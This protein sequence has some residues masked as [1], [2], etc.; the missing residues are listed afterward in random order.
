M[1][2]S[3]V[4]TSSVRRWLILSLGLLL[5][6]VIVMALAIELLRISISFIDINSDYLTNPDFQLKPIEL[7]QGVLI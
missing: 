6:A 4:S 5:L 3:V 7:G 1:K 2:H